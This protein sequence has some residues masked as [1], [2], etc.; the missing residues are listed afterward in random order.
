MDFQISGGQT[1]KCIARGS[2]STAVP[3]ASEGKLLQVN[4]IGEGRVSQK[5]SAELNDILEKCTFLLS[6]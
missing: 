3:A 4:G 5:P 2:S 6:L 1:N